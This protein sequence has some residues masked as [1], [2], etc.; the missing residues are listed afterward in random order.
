MVE[1]KRLRFLERVIKFYEKLLIID[2]H[3][4]LPLELKR[5]YV[6]RFSYWSCE[7]S[8]ILNKYFKP[9]K[10][11]CEP[12]HGQVV[13]L[14]NEHGTWKK[15]WDQDEPWG[16]AKEWRPINPLTENIFRKTTTRR[17]A[18]AKA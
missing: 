14:R 17:K 3:A 1:E 18:N 10:W 2:H 12:Y 11:G 7:R 4:S 8:I 16:F 5:E 6:Q 13:E 15:K 9:L